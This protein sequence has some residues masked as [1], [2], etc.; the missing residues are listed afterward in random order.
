MVAAPI[1]SGDPAA[2]VLSFCFA[3]G[4]VGAAFSPADVN[5]TRHPEAA[6]TDGIDLTDGEA[7][8]IELTS[9]ARQ[10]E[11]VSKRAP[12]IVSA[13]QTASLK[14]RHKLFGNISNAAREIT[15]HQG[16]AVTGA[17]FEPILHKVG[18]RL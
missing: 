3:G 11:I 12:F 14:F 10:A 1:P 7:L 8:A 9:R 6:P 15:R 18:N 4:I 16:K 13:K 2:P 17:L 5:L